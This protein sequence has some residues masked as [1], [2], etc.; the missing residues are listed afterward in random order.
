LKFDGSSW[1]GSADKFGP[2]ETRSKDFSIYNYRSNDQ[3]VYFIIKRNGSHQDLDQYFNIRIY[4]LDDN[5][6]VLNKSLSQLSSDPNAQEHLGKVVGSG[7]TDYQAKVSL[8]KDLNNSFQGASSGS[9]SFTLG[10]GGYGGVPDTTTPV[11]VGLVAGT[12]T[13]LLAGQGGGSSQ[14]AFHS[15]EDPSAA[16]KV[17]ETDQPEVAGE[18]SQQVETGFF[19]N[20]YS[21]L[22]VLLIILILALAIWRLYL[23]WKRR[24][25]EEEEEI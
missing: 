19:S 20:W 5:R 7:W 11:P 6:L 9:Y 13:T 10:F 23:A 14:Q 3:D 1:F 2:G 25:Q 4:N 16:E 15:D 17:F 24:R 21:W 8:A 18:E 12:D 22:L